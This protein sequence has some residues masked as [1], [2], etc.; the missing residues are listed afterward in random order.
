MADTTR[1]A[2]DDTSDQS[3]V[4]SDEL[5]A[6]SLARGLGASRDRLARRLLIGA[7]VTPG[8]GRLEITESD[9]THVT[10]DGSPVARVAVH[11]VAAYGAVIR[12][13][14]VG[15]GESY[16]AGWWDCDDLVSLVRILL[17]RTAR[18]RSRL[19]RIARTRPIRRLLDLVSRSTRSGKAL[20]AENIR[21]HYDIS[22][23]FFQLMLDSDMSYSCAIFDG[24]EE[25]LEDAQRRKIDRLCQKLALTAA[26]HLVE[27]GTGWGA[28]AI[29]AA[30]TY[31]C[32]VTTTT[33]SEAQ[34]RYVVDLVAKHGLNDRVRVLGADWRDL[35]GRYDK[36]VSVEMI[37]AVDWRDHDAFLSKCAT[38]LKP[39]GLACIQMIV[40]EDG[41]FERAKR[42]DDFIKALVFPGSCI[43]SVASISSAIVRATDF[44]L[45][46]LEDIGRHYAETL[47]R[48]AA[49]LA[50]RAEEVD[51]L[52]AGEEFRRL[53]SLYLAYCEGSFL[54]RHISD[55]QLLLAKSAW[56]DEL[57]VRSFR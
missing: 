21:A 32:R 20:D 5:I 50:E 17:R 48:W 52:D 28:L 29:H 36:L 18:L 15:L 44:A 34:R 4:R 26:D 47:H 12:R 2:S 16:V 33:V 57:K 9:K 54:E 40:I 31:G 23:S 30:A 3:H 41:S 24:P 11:D 19:D 49:N 46:D 6:R 35:S 7:R 27:I 43:P 38:L 14:S 1:F 8:T 42:H 45:I 22:N 56:R 37:E 51:R 10:G 39:D 55:V 25:A 13:G 53:F